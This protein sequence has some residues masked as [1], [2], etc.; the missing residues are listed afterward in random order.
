MT[1]PR[2]PLL[3]LASASPR[4]SELLWSLGIAH[5]VDPARI[6][7]V[8][9]PGET[10][11]SYVERLAGEKARAVRARRA[12]AWVLAG[13]TTVAVDDEVLE[14]PVDRDDAV[15]MLL[16]LAGRE[17][18]V[19]TGLAL[20]GAGEIVSGVEVTQ[21]RFRPF[22][23][24]VAEAYVDTGEPMDK[25]GAYGIQGLGGTLVEG[26][27]GDFSAVVGLSVPLLVRL[28]EAAGVPYRFPG[29]HPDPAPSELETLRHLLLREVAAVRRSVAA[30][31]DDASLWTPLPGWPNAGGTLALHLAGNLQHFTGTVL[32]GSD[33]LRDRD[34]EFAARGLTRAELDRELARAEE[35][36]ALGLGRVLA[37]TDPGSRPWPGALPNGP[38]PVRAFLMHLLSHT[39]YHLGQLDYHR[40]GVTGDAEGVGA[41]PL[42]DLP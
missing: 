41:L 39:A 27:E 6:D 16:R 29:A 42:G 3:V 28:M 22:D 26:I 12:G 21:V 17:H 9:R 40:R 34:R 38:R 20:A 33:Y 19:A 2:E 31:P 14:K 35:A 7:E 23:R 37:G 4:R 24:G 11:E 15:R 25:A 30:Y 8:R 32:G 1:D 13:D 36:I 5:E 10:P 18:R